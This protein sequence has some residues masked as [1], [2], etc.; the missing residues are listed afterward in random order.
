[1]PAIKCH[2]SV[3]LFT[4]EDPMDLL[5]EHAAEPRVPGTGLATLR[6]TALLHSVSC[7]MRQLSVVIMHRR[8]LGFNRR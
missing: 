3:L 4:P 1:M 2:F 5:T 6:G 8:V 7:L